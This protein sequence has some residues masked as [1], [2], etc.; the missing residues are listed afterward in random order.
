MHDFNGKNQSLL[1][2]AI[3]GQGQAA[4]GRSTRGPHG[5]EPKSPVQWQDLP[6]CKVKVI[7]FRQE[8]MAYSPMRCIANLYSSLRFAEVASA[9]FLRGLLMTAPSGR[10]GAKPCA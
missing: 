1:V 3:E 10:G 4:R 7:S 8:E 6:V 5:P 2:S 9:S